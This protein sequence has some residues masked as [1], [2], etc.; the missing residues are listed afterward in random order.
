MNKQCL[1]LC[2]THLTRESSLKTRWLLRS[3][4]SLSLELLQ[5]NLTGHRLIWIL[6]WVVALWCVKIFCLMIRGKTQ[7]I[8][9]DTGLKILRE[10]AENFFLNFFQFVFDLGGDTAISLCVFIRKKKQYNDLITITILLLKSMRYMKDEPVQWG[11]WGWH[12]DQQFPLHSFPWLHSAG[13]ISPNIEDTLYR[14]HNINHISSSM[15]DFDSC[16]FHINLLLL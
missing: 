2:E 15:N 16:V 11:R 13:R 4:S 9:L 8:E 3:R 10:A 14:I 1:K 5:E 6:F 7:L 12:R